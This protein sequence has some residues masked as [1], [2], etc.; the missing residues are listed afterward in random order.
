MHTAGAHIEFMLHL[1]DGRS[2]Q[3]FIQ[4]Q[5]AAAALTLKEPSRTGYLERTKKERNCKLIL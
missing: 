1:T 2:R 5:A 4:Q 3:I